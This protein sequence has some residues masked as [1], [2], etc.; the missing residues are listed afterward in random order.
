[1]G[2]KVVLLGSPGTGKT[3]FYLCAMSKLTDLPHKYSATIGANFVVL[4]AFLDSDTKK[5]VRVS[6]RIEQNEKGENSFLFGLWDTAGQ[7]RYKS[8]VPMYYKNA[9]VVAIMHEDTPYSKNDAVYWIEKVKSEYPNTRIIVV[10]N[11]SDLNPFQEKS[12]VNNDLVDDWVMTCTLP[13]KRYT[14]QDALLKI[15][16]LIQ[17]PPVSTVSTSNIE[18][19]EIHP[20]SEEIKKK[21]SNC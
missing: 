18:L 8:L 14:V 17:T 12:F 6:Q 19:L 1:M 9:D 13:S 11:K 7:E 21:C 15:A 10:Q 20:E 16:N 4:Q 3:S 5:V 2:K